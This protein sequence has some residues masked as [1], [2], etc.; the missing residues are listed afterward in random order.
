MKEQEIVQKEKEMDEI[1]ERID[2]LNVQVGKIHKDL[3]KRLAKLAEDNNAGKLTEG[4]QG[5]IAHLKAEILRIRASIATDSSRFA[6][7]RKEVISERLPGAITEA[8]RIRLEYD[9]KIEEVVKAL[10]DLWVTSL[11]MNNLF[12]KSDK[13]CTDFQ[14]ANPLKFS[15]LT[16]NNLTLFQA[17]HY[18]LRRM[19]EVFPEI[20]KKVKHEDYE[21]RFEVVYQ[22]LQK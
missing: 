6:T 2:K 18:Y 17:A 4:L 5:E 14:L 12:Y 8:A 21:D 19:E 7:L 9:R 15:S 1:C 22:F 13:L 3:E 11:A 16:V 20:S 10:S